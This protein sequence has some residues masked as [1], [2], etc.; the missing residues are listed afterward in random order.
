MPTLQPHKGSSETPRH[1]P[2]VRCGGRFNPTRV[3][4]K[5]GLSRHL[6]AKSCFN[7]TRVRL[8]RTSDDDTSGTTSGFNPTRVRLK[9]ITKRVEDQYVVGLQPHKGSSETAI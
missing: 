7:P 9:Q 6:R 3:R 8:K 4:L 2:N 1:Y 5:R